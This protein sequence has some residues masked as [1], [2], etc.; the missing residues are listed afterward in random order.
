MIF[1]ARI[2]ACFLLLVNLNLFAQ[3][4]MKENSFVKNPFI[5]GYYADPSILVDNNKFYVYAT[6]DPWGGDS[7]ALWVSDDFKHWHNKPLNWPTKALCTS[8]TSNDSKVWAPS[9]KKSADGKFHM[10]VSVGSEIYAGISNHPEGPWKNVKADGSPFVSTQ[11]AINVHTIDAEVFMDDNGKSYLYWGSGLH[12]VNGHCFVGEL[13]KKLD[14]F[15]STPKDITPPN[16]FEA[17]YMLK[18][19]GTYYLMYSQGKC[20]D[21]TYK[22]RYSTANNPYGPWK[23]GKNSPV[24]STDLSK[25]IIG[26]GHHTILQWKE[27]YYIIYHRIIETKLPGLHRE[28]CIDEM[29][30]DAAGNINVIHPTNDGVQINLK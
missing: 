28:L 2:T 22:V 30:F 26:P 24:L 17:P 3:K 4:S 12:W 20:T 21:S 15:I 25:N 14:G 16:Y 10:F 19:N 13:N 29:S 27:K 8:P 7:L 9:V 6:I 18:R 1:V 11:K 23:E 5:P